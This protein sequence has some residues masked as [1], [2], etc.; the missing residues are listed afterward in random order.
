[1]SIDYTTDP[2]GRILSMNYAEAGGYSGELFA[3]FNNFGDISA[4]VD[5]NGFTKYAAIYDLNNSLRNELYNP[6]QRINVPFGW[7]ARNGDITIQVGTDRDLIIN[8][9]GSDF[10]ITNPWGATDTMGWARP[11]KTTKGG[12]DIEPC[13]DEWM[14]YKRCMWRCFNKCGENP[15]KDC[16]GDVYK[17]DK[18]NDKKYEE[19]WHKWL[20]TKI[21]AQKFIEGSILGLLGVAGDAALGKLLPSTLFLA[22]WT[23]R[24]LYLDFLLAMQKGEF[25][26][27]GKTIWESYDTWL[28]RE[29]NCRDYC[30]KYEPPNP[31]SG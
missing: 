23:S 19:R 25:L 9:E 18:E 24:S 17:E 3:V 16:V 30:R 13:G 11:P 26:I 6:P 2:N 4:W 1:L 15:N 12:G 10:S 20:D 8:N 22:V 14:P 7:N 31:S 28:N 29:K 21:A 5:S 27:G